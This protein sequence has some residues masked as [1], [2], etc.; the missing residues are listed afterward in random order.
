MAAA[1]AAE[2]LEVVAVPFPSSHLVRDGT[3]FLDCCCCQSG[4]LL[5]ELPHA[6]NG[7]TSE[8]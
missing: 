7:C 4:L 5:A 8:Q 6:A 2:E 1:M 3:D